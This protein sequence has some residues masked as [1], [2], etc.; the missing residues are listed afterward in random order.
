[1]FIDAL[2]VYR[3]GEAPTKLPVSLSYLLKRRNAL[4]ML[5]STQNGSLVVSGVLSFAFDDV[6]P[7]ESAIVERY[8]IFAYTLVIELG[9]ISI[10]L[11][12]CIFL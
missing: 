4:A 7:L 3:T 9:L 1:M 11:Q 2:S 5:A 10:L 6:D 8:A 12:L